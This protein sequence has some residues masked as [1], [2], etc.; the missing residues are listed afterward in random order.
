MDSPPSS[1]NKYS[2]GGSARSEVAGAG[3][4]HFRGSISGSSEADWGSEGHVNQWF[5]ILCSIVRSFLRQSSNMDLVK[6]RA[7]AFKHCQG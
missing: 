3:P 5:Y 1:W 2:T 7:Y 6:C 4:M